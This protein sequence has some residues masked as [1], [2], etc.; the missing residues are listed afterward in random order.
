MNAPRS[1]CGASAGLERATAE[2]HTLPAFI[3]F[4][5][6]CDGVRAQKRADVQ[7][8]EAMSQGRSVTMI[9]FIE[10]GGAYDLT[11]EQHGGSR[12]EH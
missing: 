6:E 7:C 1:I 8:S 11:P 2:E 3:I 9:Q 10:T 4:V 12:H 5:D